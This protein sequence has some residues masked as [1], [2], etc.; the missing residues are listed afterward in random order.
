M[1][2]SNSRAE[3]LEPGS[4]GGVRRVAS[5]LVAGVVMVKVLDRVLAGGG[6]IV[7]TSIDSE[8]CF[9]ACLMLIVRVL[10]T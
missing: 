2:A 4:A 5:A 7:E 1:G 6:V 3:T 10:Q 9:P 8:D